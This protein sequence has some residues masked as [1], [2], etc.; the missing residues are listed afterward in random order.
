[1]GSL[2][3]LFRKSTGVILLTMVLVGL[4]VVLV[5][6]LPIQL[7]PQTQRPRV[8]AS[9]THTGISAIDFSDDYADTIESQ[10]L[11]IEG[12]DMLESSY[13][14]DRS[15]FTLTFDWDTDPDDARTEVDTTMATIDARLPARLRNSYQVRFFSG[16]NAGYLIIGVNAPS[17]SPEELYEMLDT[18]VQSRLDQT[19]D[20]E[21][22]EIYP[23]EEL[24]VDVT[25]RPDALLAAG[26][27]IADV[28]NALQTNATTR[29]I[30]TLEEGDRS[31]TVRY[32]RGSEDLSRLEH[33]EIGRRG[34]Q[35]IRLQDV[36][37]VEIAYALPS[38]VF[39][40]NGERGIQ[41][42]ATPIDGGNVR[43]MGR[44]IENTL[45]E[46]REDRLIPP[47]TVFETYL[48]PADFI[49]RSVRNV[50]QAAVIGAILAMVVVFLGLGEW[51]NTVLIGVSLPTTIILSFILMYGFDVSLNLI[52]LGGI[53]LAVG[54]VIDS[55]IVVIENIHRLRLTRAPIGSAAELR[56]IIIDAVAEVRVPVIAST[57]TSVLVFLPLS[58]TA[59]L[60]SAILGDQAQT[61]VFSLLIAMTVALTLLP[62]LAF[63]MFRRHIHTGE[64]L[65][66]LQ[67]ISYLTME[68]MRRA[69]RAVLT[70]ML[71]R[72]ALTVAGLMLSAALLATAIVVVLP[73]I[74]R[75][76]VSAP[77]SDRIVIFFRN[78]AVQDRNEIIDKV[79][80]EL[81]AR[82]QARVGPEVVDTY[83]DVLGRFNRLFINLR[84]SDT[85]DMVLG[86]LQE[87]FPSEGEWYFNVMEWD[88]AQLPLP[89]TMDLQISVIGDD[90]ATA[91]GLLEQLR[92]IVSDTERYSWSFTN[93][94]TSYSDDLELTARSDIIEGTPGYTES[95]LLSLITTILGGTTA[96]EF[97]DG[98]DRIPV[99]ASYPEEVIEGRSRLQNM[100]L[101]F[102][103][104]AVPMKHFFDFTEST[105]VS[106]IASED[107][108]RIFRLY[109]RMAPATTATERA[110]SQ[111][112]VREAV[113]STLDLPPGF[114][115]R[116][117]NPQEELDG[118]IQSL[119][120][121]LAVSLVLIFLLLAF[122]F[123]SV[124]IPLII[125]VSVPFGFIGVVASLYVFNSTLSLNSM[126]GTILLGGIVV[127][128]AIIMIDFYLRL[129]DD[130]GD[131]IAAI[132]ESATLRFAPILMTMLTTVF[133]MLPI[134]I[135]LGEGS[136][137]V[138]PLG[139]AVSG[140]LVVSTLFTLFL[141]PGLM[142]LIN[143][144][145][146]DV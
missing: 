24:E 115:I 131:R 132:V 40:M 93:P 4:G 3:F 33:I 36:A 140:G 90:P 120:V 6:Q 60:T 25:L 109:G 80:P 67:R 70:A 145:R 133:G 11:S 71:R 137:I 142:S 99:R 48:D 26:L 9:I 138:Q 103:G 59:P 87:E 61:V 89:R 114:S 63:L 45:A 141:V 91:V 57:L 65:A 143:I 31:Y 107:G 28:E 43:E 88:P 32:R 18:S 84:S 23:V 81:Q 64:S 129:H 101:P 41:I 52:S 82:I 13:E 110:E 77:S 75:E 146:E 144:R 7:Y 16:E 104:S 20:A 22:V 38:R 95:D 111:A 105:G 118:A 46:A 122:Q 73:Q 29:S 98:G 10:L 1:M 5:N 117:D 2:S 125:L 39:V 134:A 50:I 113:E 79:I 27:T 112:L 30:G 139:I 69:Y 108:E 34:D 54:M 44:E 130:T 121:A 86:E 106:G 135:G 12:V 76:I 19:S 85:A 119:F 96:V 15:S 68:R 94:S 126:L 56:S 100:L 136:N 14:N 37:E 78:T 123:N 21:T 74:P 47:D 83:A 58:L 8:R 42:T 102:G 97:T 55:S 62:L 53:A 128:N 35:R 127:N 49:D 116:F 124:V 92:E 72:R 17:V 51:H 66:G